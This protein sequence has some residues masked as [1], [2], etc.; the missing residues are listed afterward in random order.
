M[1]YLIE[2]MLEDQMAICD[3]QM[4]KMEKF[5]KHINFQHNLNK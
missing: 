1:N 2:L 3:W 4:L 5:K